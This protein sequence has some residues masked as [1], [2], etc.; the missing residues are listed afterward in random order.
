MVGPYP[1]AGVHVPGLHFT[2]MVGARDDE[3]ARLPPTPTKPLPGVYSTSTPMIGTAHVVVGRNVNH[4]RF[5]T[6]SDGRPGL[7][8]VHP[9]QKSARLP[10]PGLCSGSTS[11]RPVTGIEA[12]ETF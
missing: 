3:A 9:W 6:E 7:A 1:L 8:A 4:A 10:V 12:P 11:G 5:G 2:E